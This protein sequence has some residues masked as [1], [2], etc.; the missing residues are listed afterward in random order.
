MSRREPKRRTARRFF[1]WFLLAFIVLGCA[2]LYLLLRPPAPVLGPEPPLVRELRAAAKLPPASPTV[3]VSTGLGQFAQSDHVSPPNAYSFLEEAVASLPAWTDERYDRTN[4]RD[5]AFLSQKSIPA[6]EDMREALRV[7]QFH[8]PEV[9]LN[10]Y[11]RTGPFWQ[12]PGLLRERA[13]VLSMDFQDHAGAMRCTLDAVELQLLLSMDGGCAEQEWVAHRLREAVWVL[14]TVAVRAASRE[15]LEEARKRY[16]TLTERYMPDPRRPIDFTARAL[17]ST[18]RSHFADTSKPTTA[19]YFFN[20]VGLGTAYRAAKGAPN[21]RSAAQFMREHRPA[22]VEAAALSYPDYRE[23]YAENHAG[24][25]G[26]GH[27][28]GFE[29]YAVALGIKRAQTRIAALR[30]AMHIILALEQYSLDHNRYPEVLKDLCPEYLTPIPL[31]PFI[32]APFHYRPRVGT[33]MCWPS[34]G[35]SPNPHSGPARAPTPFTRRGYS[36]PSPSQRP[37]LNG[38]STES[39]FVKTTRRRIP[40]CVRPWPP[41]RLRERP[42]PRTHSPAPLIWPPALP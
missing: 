26:P 31:D 41:C 7:G 14:R 3:I 12:I 18:P 15:L 25:C 29:P 11:A 35:R 24:I 40:G 38:T 9:R 23:W 5:H 10:M 32:E 42:S 20:Y 30:H 2:T 36:L 13:L 8:Y 27:R 33:P 19:Y 21:R 4:P 16:T 34:P 1:F 37:S 6:V 17:G 22:F 28:N 39:S